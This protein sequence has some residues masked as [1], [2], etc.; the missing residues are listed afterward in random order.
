ML[1]P[2]PKIAVLPGDGIGPEVC[3]EAVKVLHAVS[4]KF[5]Y[6]VGRCFGTGSFDVDHDEIQIF[7]PLRFMMVG[8]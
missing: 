5:D 3:R 1:S 6:A 8:L 2:M 4:A 7:Q